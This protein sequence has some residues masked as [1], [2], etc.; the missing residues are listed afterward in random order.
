M[1]VQR[2]A[3]LLVHFPTSIL[4]CGRKLRT[5]MSFIHTMIAYRK[6]SKNIFVIITEKNTNLDKFEII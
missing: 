5:P 1:Y 4:H 6:S 3:R 2:N